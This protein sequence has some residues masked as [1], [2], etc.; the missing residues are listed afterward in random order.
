MRKS[1]PEIEKAII[2]RLVDA[3]YDDKCQ[4]DS[5]VR[6]KYLHYLR[7]FNRLAMKFFN[8]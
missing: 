7:R 6:R 3:V 2:H 1:R 5:L 4:M 8:R